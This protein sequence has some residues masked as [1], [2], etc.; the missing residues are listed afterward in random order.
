MFTTHVLLALALAA[1]PVSATRTTDPVIPICEIASIEDQSVP[2]ADAGVLTILTVKEGMS[3]TKGAEIGRVDDSEAQAQ[4][5]VKKLEYDVANSTATSDIEVRA[6]AAAAKVAEAAY[7]K[8]KE[9]NDKFK[10]TVT[11]IDIL[12]AQLEWE[13]RRLGIEQA[14]QKKSEAELTANAKNAEVGAAKVALDRRVLRAPFDGMVVKLSKKPGEWVAPGEPVVQIVGVNRL[15]VMGNLDASDWGPADIDG[16][17]VTVEVTLPRGRTVK[18]PGKVT[19]VSPVVSLGQL[20]VWA[21]IAP[22]LEAGLPV[23]RAGLKASMTIHASKPLT[24]PGSAPSTPA[25]AAT[26]STTTKGLGTP[27]PR[28]AGAGTPK[29]GTPTSTTKTAPP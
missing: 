28:P 16:R 1:D 11:A 14:A 6:A 15:R 22:S 24:K 3:V 10:G 7:L 8:L 21:E 13:H 27:N 29:A 18:V 20:P 17:D 25:K 26:P 2:S 5:A 12:R 4:L 9:S 23:V 19:Y